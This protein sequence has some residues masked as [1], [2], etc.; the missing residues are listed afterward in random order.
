MQGVLS[1]IRE[2]LAQDLSVQRLAALA[3]VSEVHFRRVFP[4]SIGAPPHRY[5][6]AADSSRRASC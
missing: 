2:N 1:H 6:L 4:D 5:I 3:R